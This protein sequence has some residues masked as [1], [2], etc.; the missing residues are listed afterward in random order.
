MLLGGRWVW[1]GAPYKQLKGLLER[2]SGGGG[3][4]RDLS[5]RGRGVP[6]F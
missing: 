6:C 3:W 4:D 5:K 1:S 2:A